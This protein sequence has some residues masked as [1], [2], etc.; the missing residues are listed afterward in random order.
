MKKLMILLALGLM[1]QGAWAGNAS[2]CVQL[3]HPNNISGN[4][5][6]NICNED[7]EVS[8]GKG[9][10]KLD[11]T[12]TIHPGVEHPIDARP[13]EYIRWDACRGANSIKGWT[14]YGTVEC[15]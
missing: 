15:D 4:A 5:L 1:A 12:W 10:G 3:T 14:N 11:S 2:Y 13:G 9:G 7:I 6:K 8:W